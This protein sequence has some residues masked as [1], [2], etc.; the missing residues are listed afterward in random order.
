M[1]AA[2]CTSWAR[3]LERLL[4]ELDIPVHL[5]AE[6]RH[7]HK[8]GKTV[9]ALELAGGERRTFDIVVSNMEVIPCYEHLLGEAPRFMR[10]LK[11]FQPAC[12]GLVLHLGTDKIY[13][14]L[15][16]HNFFYSENQ[17]K[18]FQSVFQKHQLPEDP[19]LYVVAPTRTDP[20]KAPAG[21]D[22]IKILPHIPPLDPDSGI[23][24]AD[25]LALRE[26]MLD[27]MERCGLKDLRQHIITEDFMTP[28]DIE[29][30]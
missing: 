29:R 15:A 22:N 27:K 26:R 25:Y 28:V 6:I 20:S 23:T 2:A 21:C 7:L 3:G 13:P 14:E 9:T 4:Q 5:N 12:S 11:K 24:H 17:H 19:T 16:H 18:H 1:C 8:T 30:R 10:K